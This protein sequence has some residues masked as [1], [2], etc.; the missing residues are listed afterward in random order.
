[1]PVSERGHV[2]GAVP[3]SLARRQAFS[4]AGRATACLQKLTG[5]DFQYRDEDS[6]EKRLEAIRKARQWWAEEGS[7]KYTFDHI[8]K[9]MREAVTRTEAVPAATEE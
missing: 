3:L 4:Y 1:M 8:E 6:A 7:E 5:M 9:Q 2:T